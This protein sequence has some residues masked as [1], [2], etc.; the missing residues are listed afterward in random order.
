MSG[1]T[2]EQTQQ[3]EELGYV[4]L[5]GLFDPGELQPLIEELDKRNR[6]HCAGVITRM[7]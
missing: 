5:K 3:Y 1:L 6:S 7:G 2:S 4:L